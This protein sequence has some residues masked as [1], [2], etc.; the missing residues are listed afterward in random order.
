MELVWLLQGAV[1]LVGLAQAWLP[2]PGPAALSPMRTDRPPRFVTVTLKSAGRPVGRTS[3]RTR[4]SRFTNP[5]YAGTGIAT[6]L[7]WPLRLNAG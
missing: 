5:W 3:R 6:A 7:L 2:N 4:W 1:G